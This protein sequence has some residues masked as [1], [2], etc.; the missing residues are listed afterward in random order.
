MARHNRLFKIIREQGSRG[1]NVKVQSTF[2]SGS[3]SSQPKSTQV[4][5]YPSHL[6]MRKSR[7]THGPAAIFSPHKACGALLGSSQNLASNHI[8]VL[9]IPQNMNGVLMF[10]SAGHKSLNR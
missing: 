6:I 5:K 1:T 9:P 2:P 7:Y 4:Q 3:S 10:W 8:A